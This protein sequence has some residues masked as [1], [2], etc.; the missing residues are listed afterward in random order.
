MS[1]YDYQNDSDE[2][3]ELQP[4]ITCIKAMPQQRESIVY[5]DGLGNLVLFDTRARRGE[6][7]SLYSRSSDGGH[8]V[9]LRGGFA[10]KGGVT[11]VEVLGDGTHIVSGGR[12]GTVCVW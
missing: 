4:A 2:D 6:A 3:E 9:D 11:A 5:G 10:H 12:D 7:M 1:E 8:L